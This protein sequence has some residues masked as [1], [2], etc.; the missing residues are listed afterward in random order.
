LNVIT[1]NAQNL[2]STALKKTDE[3]EQSIRD[4]V[5]FIQKNTDRFVVISGDG[6]LITDDNKTP[7][8][9]FAINYYYEKNDDELFEENNLILINYQEV[10]DSI[11]NN[12]IYLFEEGILSYYHEEY[13]SKQNTTLEIFFEDGKMSNY[14]LINCFYSMDIEDY[15]SEI[16][17]DYEN[18]DFHGSIF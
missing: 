11:R 10:E 3:K 13:Y 1:F 18:E 17:S 5:N 15:I 6:I 16:R 7:V 14:Y 12:K 2:I 8:G 9:G 4:Y